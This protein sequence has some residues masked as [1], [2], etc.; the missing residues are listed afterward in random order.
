ME[1][2][3]G[4]IKELFE[5]L[6][7][8][9]FYWEKGDINYK[10]RI[11]NA[12]QPFITELEELGVN[13]EFSLSLLFFGSEFL[14]SFKIV[15]NYVDNFVDNSQK[16]IVDECVKIFNAEARNFTEK[17]ERENNLAKKNNVLVYKSR[18]NK[19]EKVGIDAV[20]YRKL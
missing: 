8:G 16:N 18:P 4:R 15:D 13:K 1:E 17:E 3:R 2:R 11:E 7:Q 12:F 20:L 6:K 10:K 9:H 19:G 14:E 5:K